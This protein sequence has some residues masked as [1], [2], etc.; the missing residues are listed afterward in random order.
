MPSPRPSRRSPTRG[1]SR[2][3]GRS[4]FDLSGVEARNRFDPG[5]SSSTLVIDLSGPDLP[6]FLGANMDPAKLPLAIV[7]TTTG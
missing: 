3:R 5:F 1:R 4:T 7:K 2:R 6:I